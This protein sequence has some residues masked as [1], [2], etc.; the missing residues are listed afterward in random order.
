MI[1]YWNKYK[2]ASTLL[3]IVV[4]K[5]SVVSFRM[6]HPLFYTLTILP[7]LL[8]YQLLLS[9]QFTSS[10]TILVLFCIVISQIF[11]YNIFCRYLSVLLINTTLS[12]IFRRWVNVRFCV[13]FNYWQKSLW[14]VTWFCCFLEEI[15]IICCAIILEF[16]RRRLLKVFQKSSV[17]ANRR[18]SFLFLPVS[19]WT[20]RTKR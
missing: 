6:N 5:E 10:Q 12:E 1:D 11:N 7:Q 20:L 9:Y 17:L 15:S 3:D 14:L 8:F 18:N 16:D 13:Y 2:I 4:P 19:I